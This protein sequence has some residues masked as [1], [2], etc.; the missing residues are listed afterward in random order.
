[1]LMKEENTVVYEGLA[2]MYL[3]VPMSARSIPVVGSCRLQNRKLYLAFPTTK[4]CFDL[5]EVP[6]ETLGHQDKP[7]ALEVQQTFKMAGPKG[8]MRVCLSYDR[9]M[10]AFIGRGTEGDDRVKYLTFLLFR[11]GHSLTQLKE[12]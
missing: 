5:P 7:E 11:P 9:R 1:M 4:I 2:A 10:K 12:L 3:T 8:E 6:K